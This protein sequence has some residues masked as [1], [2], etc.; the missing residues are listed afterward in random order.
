M[1]QVENIAG[2][3]AAAGTSV[4]SED[5]EARKALW[6]S[7]LGYAMDGFDLLIL[8][9]ML[10]AISADLHLTPTAAASLVTATLIGA[11][12]GGL[13]FGMLSDRLGRV[14]VLTWTIV[15]FAVFT[16]HVRVRPGL[17]GS[18]CLPRHSGIGSGRRVRHRHGA[19]GGSLAR[20]EE[21]A[22]IVLCGSGLAAWRSDG[23]S[24]HADVAAGDRLARHVRGRNFSCPGGLFSSAVSCMSRKSSSPTRR[25]TRMRHSRCGSWLPIRRPPRSVSG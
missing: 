24:G 5:G 9:F 12:M 17:L 20:F 23:G 3:S 16:G 21:G 22:G 7:A 13:I 6:G 15:L 14:R 2:L 1:T 10:Q 4:Q 8:G 18:T 25:T 11:V 19:G